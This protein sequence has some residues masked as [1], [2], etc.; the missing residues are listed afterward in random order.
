MGYARNAVLV[1]SAQAVIAVG[2]GYGT[3]SE[4]AYALDFKIPV[5]GLS[6][7][8]FSRNNQKDKLIIR[9]RNA[10]SAVNKALKLLKGK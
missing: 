9:V 7:W 4:I 8:S 10:K 3:L 2:G 1:K 6:T 5:I